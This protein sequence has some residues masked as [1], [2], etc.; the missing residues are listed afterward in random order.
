MC[1]ESYYLTWQKNQKTEKG[2]Q[3]EI[4]NNKDERQGQSTRKFF[5]EISDKSQ[6]RKTAG[7]E[8]WEEKQLF[9]VH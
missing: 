4:K 2:K 8:T 5:K 7:S 3:H 6:F 9:W 1:Q